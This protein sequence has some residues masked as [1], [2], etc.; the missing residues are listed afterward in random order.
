MSIEET[1]AGAYIGTAR[2]RRLER[3]E[4]TLEYLETSRLA[5]ALDLCPNCFRQLFEAATDREA[6]A[7][8]HGLEPTSERLPEAASPSSSNPR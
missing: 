2:L 4:A 3:G 7:A 5:K 1:S 6:L 8:R